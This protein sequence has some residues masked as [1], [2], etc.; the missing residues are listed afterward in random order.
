MVEGRLGELTGM[1]LIENIL[2]EI[3]GTNG[4]LRIELSR[5]EIEHALKIKSAHD[6]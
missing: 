4:I 2:L 1:E 5:E 3:R 6:I